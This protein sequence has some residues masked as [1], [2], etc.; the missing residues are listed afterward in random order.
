MLDMRY[1]K[2]N[3]PLTIVFNLNT[4]SHISNLKSQI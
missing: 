3:G 4:K 1:E 2:A